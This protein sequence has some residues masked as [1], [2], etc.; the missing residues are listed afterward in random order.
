METIRLTQTTTKTGC[1]AKVAA[2]DLRE[3]LKGVRFS[4]SDKNL[5]IDA[6]HFDDAAI[7]R[8]S[9]ELALVQ[10]LDFFTPLVDD[11][12]EFGAI[13][14]TNALSDVY[15]MGGLPK[16]AMGILGYPVGQIP[17]SIISEILQGAGD[18]LE[19]ANASM[20]GGHSVDDDTLKFGLSVTG[21][22]H[23]E[24]IWSNQG[25]QVGD[26]LILTKPLGT[27]TLTTALKRGV[28][29]AEEVSD[30]I[31]SMK[32]LNRV[33]ELISPEENAA[34]HAAT[35]ITG[36]GLSG[37]ALQMAKASQVGFRIIVSKL[38]RF[39]LASES[40]IRGLLTKAHRSNQRYTKDFNRLLNLSSNDELLIH[41][42]QTSGGLLLSVDPKRSS[43]LVNTL[44]PQ[45][46]STEIIGEVIKGPHIEYIS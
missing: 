12:Y 7:Y 8:I 39:R 3:V 10:T 20:V 16:T 11:P 46:P 42:P 23:P 6:S 31:A 18:T 44:K 14:S 2:E 4:N 15:A 13:A 27:G 25:A 28:F 21:F 43:S 40:L 29:S 9:D 41:D 34:I 30:C 5:I 33:P 1:A 36:F 35:D 32:A 22:V 45:F 19:K 37:H 24:R 38:P 26:H 17:N